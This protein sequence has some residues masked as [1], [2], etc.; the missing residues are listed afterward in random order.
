MRFDKKTTVL[1][2]VKHCSQYFESSEIF[3]GHGTDNYW[4]EAVYLTIAALDLPPDIS[5]D[6]AD[7]VIEPNKLKDLISMME[8]RVNSRKPLPYLTGKAWYRGYK[9]YVNENTIVPRSP[10]GEMIENEFFGFIN[11]ESEVKILDL[12]TGSG[13]LAILS[14]LYA[15]RAKVD[16]IDISKG[17]LDIARKNI[18][19][20]KLEDRVSLIESDLFTN[21][22]GEYDIIISNPPYVGDEEYRDLPQEYMHEP[23]IALVSDNKG[24][25]IPLKIVNQS[26]KY[27]KDGGSLILEVG[28]GMQGFDNIVSKINRN[29]LEFNSGGDG[30]IHFDKGDLP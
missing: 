22:N 8:E 12:C 6:E 4:D 2:F 1:D 18:A 19:L 9:F 25:D 14:A 20:Y 13:A 15:P 10:I 28:Y 5:A 16:A 30:V 7:M 17:A 26:K 11:H 3:L 27:L 21:C 24:F 23:E 29:W